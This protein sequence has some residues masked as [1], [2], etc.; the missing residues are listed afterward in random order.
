MQFIL[1]TI[2]WV[3]KERLPVMFDCLISVANIFSRQTAN[4]PECIFPV[5]HK[6]CFS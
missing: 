6:K 1:C 3:F 4:I 5:D 2:D